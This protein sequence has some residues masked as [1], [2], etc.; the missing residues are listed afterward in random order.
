V[1]LLLEAAA[2]RDVSIYAV[3]T[4]RSD[5]LGECSASEIFWSA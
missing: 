2:R 5:F 3:I 1:K 4:M